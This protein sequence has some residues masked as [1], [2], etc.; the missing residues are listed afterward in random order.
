[1]WKKHQKNQSIKWYVSNK[2][3]ILLQS[4]YIFLVVCICVSTVV[5]GIEVYVMQRNYDKLHQK[6][7]YIINYMKIKFRNYEECDEQID[8]E[9][10]LYLITIDNLRANVTFDYNNL[11]YVMILDYDHYSETI[12]NYSIFTQ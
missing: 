7:L 4:L 1:M 2:G 6:E 8:V 12:E 5:K 11:Q 9:G 3:S 10:T